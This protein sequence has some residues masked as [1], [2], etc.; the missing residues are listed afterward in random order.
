MDTLE[1]LLR[2]LRRTSDMWCISRRARGR[3]RTREARRRRRVGSTSIEV[4]TQSRNGMCG[5]QRIKAATLLVSSWGRSSHVGSTMNVR[6]RHVTTSWP[7]R[8][9]ARAASASCARA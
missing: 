6:I 2:R 9:I 8:H 3:S 5:W 1:N 7:P 4:G